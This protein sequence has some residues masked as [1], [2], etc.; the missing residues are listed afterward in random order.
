MKD[1]DSVTIDKIIDAAQAG[2][3]ALIKIYDRA[4]RTLGTG[5]RNL[6]KIFDVE[7]IIISG[8]G[9]LAG[10]LLFK[11]M[12][13]TLSKDISF[14]EDAVTRL[15]IQPWQPTNYARAAG[16][17]VLQE[18]YQSPANRVVPII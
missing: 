15:F 17:L 11:P 18:I 12:Q 3:Q 10:D 8:K 2:N 1:I 9:V 6:N 4:G 5:I 16:A 14:A 7:K 13:K